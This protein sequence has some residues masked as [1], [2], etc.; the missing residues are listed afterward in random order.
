MKVA[1]RRAHRAR[2]VPHRG[3]VLMRAGSPRR[4]GAA[5][6]RDRA[7]LAAGEMLTSSVS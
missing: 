2:S 4:R 7:L 1:A 6:L 3:A 5:A